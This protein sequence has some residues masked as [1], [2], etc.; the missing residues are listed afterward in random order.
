MGWPQPS[1]SPPPPRRRRSAG[2]WVALL[3]LGL[4]VCAIAGW[5]ALRL[6]GPARPVAVARPIA[7]RGDL[8]A[9]EAATVALFEQASPSVVHITNVGVRSDVFGLNVMEIP[10]G[11]GS[12]FVWDERGY[13]VT[14]FH[15][16]QNARRA[17]VRL[18]D[19]ST[20]RAEPVGLAPDQD[21]AVLKI[22]APASKLR[23]ILIGSSRDLKVGQKVFAIG[24]PFGLDHTLTTG[25]ISALGREIRSVTSRPIRGVI[26]TDAAINPGNSGG[27]LL[28]SAGRLIGVNTAI[29]SPG[30]EGGGGQGT[31][32]GIGFAV[33]VDAVN[34]LVPQLITGGRVIRAGMG[35]Q[36]A[37]DQ[38]LERLGLQGA[39]ILAVVDGSPAA[40]AGLRPTRRDDEG[41]ILL[42]DLIIAVDGTPIHNGDDVTALLEDKGVGTQIRLRI[43]R[44]TGEVDVPVTLAALD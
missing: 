1:Y 7:A 6:R 35:V 2:P 33:P 29:L 12:G 26:Q 38:T 5:V 14:N 28:D 31:F 32:L 43:R 4:F 42:G 19:Q 40:R 15:V 13:I 3:I 37:P 18:S 44:T 9:D 24:N 41:N 34:R 10:Q 22:D 25:V 8:A 27:P 16:V 20:W 30:A 17:E 39:L 36:L 11:T 23:P 21:L